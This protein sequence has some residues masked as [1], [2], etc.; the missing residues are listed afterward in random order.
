MNGVVA[1]SASRSEESERDNNNKQPALESRLRFRFIF[2]AL[3]R[4]PLDLRVKLGD[5]ELPAREKE[6]QNTDL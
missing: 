6:K 3:A 4:P 5:L 2:P 1:R